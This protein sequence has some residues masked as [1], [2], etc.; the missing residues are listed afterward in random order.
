MLGSLAAVVFVVACVALWV[1][2]G[3]LYDPVVS[4]RSMVY[5][6][7]QW[8]AAQLDSA[9]Y[10]ALGDDRAVARVGRMLSLCGFDAAERE[11]AYAVEPGMSA[12][13]VALKLSRAVRHRCG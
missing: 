5:V 9:L 4:N 12:W 3:Y 13:R 11:G 10:A 7:R 1:A 2:K 6:H 8:S